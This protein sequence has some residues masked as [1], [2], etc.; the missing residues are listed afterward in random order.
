MTMA[1]EA[2]APPQET[3]TV[4]VPGC[5]E[6]PMFHAQETLPAASVFEAPRPWAVERVP[7][8]DSARRVQHDVVADARPLGMTCRRPHGSRP[9]SSA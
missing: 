3:E 4:P 2:V 6:L 8:G 5:V 7:A 9:D 1:A